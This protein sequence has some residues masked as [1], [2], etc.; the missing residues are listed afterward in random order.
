MTWRAGQRLTANI[1]KHLG[2]GLRLAPQP[3][4]QLDYRITDPGVHQICDG[5]SAGIEAQLADMEGVLSS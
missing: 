4:D 1:S 2:G 3:R 5:I